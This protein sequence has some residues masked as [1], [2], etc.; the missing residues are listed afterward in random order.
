M[1][2]LFIGYICTQRE[3]S[4]DVSKYPHTGLGTL[5]CN[6]TVIDCAV[7]IAVQ[8]TE[9]DFCEGTATVF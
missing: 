1:C 9:D 7:V 2:S 5:N 4:C 6:I 3:Q 8:Q